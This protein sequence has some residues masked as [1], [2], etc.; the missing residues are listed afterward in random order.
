MGDPGAAGWNAETTLPLVK[1]LET[2]DAEGE[3]HGRS[4]PVHLMNIPPN[5]PCGVALL[6][7]CEQTGIPR[8]DGRSR[9]AIISPPPA[10]PW[11]AKASSGWNPKPFL[12]VGLACSF[13]LWA[14]TSVASRSMTSGSAAVAPWP[15]A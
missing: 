12:Y 1:R 14:V 5:D 4:G 15:G 10:L 2:N 11:S 6:D 7:A 13:S 8:A 3:H 9:Q